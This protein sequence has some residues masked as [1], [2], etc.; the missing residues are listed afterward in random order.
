[1]SGVL[2]KANRPS[3]E[4]PLASKD[5][6]SGPIPE[7]AGYWISG[8]TGENDL[9][10]LISSPI[11]RKNSGI[12]AQSSALRWRQGGRNR[13]SQ[14]RRLPAVIPEQVRKRLIVAGASI[15]DH[16]WD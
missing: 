6:S 11:K 15:T 16:G 10:D 12:V 4:R 5:R 8:K 14:P 7:G 3:E 13:D 2:Y 9:K 1:M